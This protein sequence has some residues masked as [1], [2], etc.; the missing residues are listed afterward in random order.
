M[1]M[2][3]L[4]LQKDLIQGWKGEGIQ[5]LIAANSFYWIFLVVGLLDSDLE[6]R[7]QNKA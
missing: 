4:Q 3:F 5:L 6:L 2:G 7:L 1:K